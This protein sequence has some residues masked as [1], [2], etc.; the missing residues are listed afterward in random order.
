MEQRSSLHQV[1]APVINVFASPLKYYLNKY[2]NKNFK[3]SK[4]Q[5]NLNGSLK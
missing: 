4:L 3:I 2:S 5:I 1:L